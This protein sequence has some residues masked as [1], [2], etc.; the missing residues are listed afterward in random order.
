[1]ESVKGVKVKKLKYY[2]GRIFNMSFKNF[3]KTI[4]IVHK[5]SGKS[6]IVLFFDMIYCSYKYLAG[7]TD[8]F[9]FYFED[10]TNEQ[11]KTYV[12]RG[13]NNNYI[14]ALNDRNYYNYFRD[15]VLFN[16]TFKDYIRRDY[17]DLT[18][19]SLDDF[20]EF[21]N[22][23]KTIIVKPVD[24]SGG[25]GISKIT[26]DNSLDVE[27]LYNE[28]K[29]TKRTLV[30]E[31]V[32]QHP[33]MNRLCPT[34]VN[35]LRIVTVKV[36]DEVH[37]MLRAIRIGNGINPVD[38]FHSGGMFSYFDENGVINNIAADRQCTIFTKH[39]TT[40]VDIVGFKIP[41]YKEAIELVKKA[42][43]VVP[44]IGYIGFDVAISEDGPLLIEGNEL[45]G[46]DIYQSKVHLS[47]DKKG[48]KPLFDKVIFNK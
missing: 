9:L 10:L 22:K 48:L 7:Y 12:T 37:I 34:S 33:E 14:R 44:E 46:Y 6:R 18:E 35:T 39:P 2:I 38:N 23:N 27:K 40:G 47:D 19:S 41:Y 43:K 31:C 13:V 32:R 5:R 20:K 1:M 17:I 24:S 15:K 8:Y 29:E 4:G 3:F 36:N 30:E 11:R 21:L 45:P 28:L 26:V 42:A 16:K 25:F